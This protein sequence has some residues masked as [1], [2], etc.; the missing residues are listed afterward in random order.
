MG[1]AQNAAR[2]LISEF[3]AAVEELSAARHRLRNWLTPHVTDPGHLYDL[4]LAADEACANAVE[5]GHN[6]DG[7]VIRL[8]AA[9]EGDAIRI[10]VTDHGRWV[11]RNDGPDAVRGL[12]DSQRGRGLALM[13]ALAP[14]TRLT[15]SE[16]GTTVEFTVPLNPRR[17]S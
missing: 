14:D 17:D 2:P 15:V 1:D 12:P 4:L 10:T 9:I 6:G 3:P 11:P 7:G 13:R 16:T 8:S 5:H